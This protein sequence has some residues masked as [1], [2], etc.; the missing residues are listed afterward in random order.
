M[1]VLKVH[2]AAVSPPRTHVASSERLASTM[3]L[4]YM[5]ACCFRGEGSHNKK[6]GVGGWG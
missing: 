4:Q 2:T 6:I 1:F 5:A 3:P